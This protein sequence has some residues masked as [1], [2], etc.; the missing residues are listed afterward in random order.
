MSGAFAAVLGVDRGD[1]TR[2]PPP[3]WSLC[4]CEDGD[5]PQ[6]TDHPPHMA[7]L[8][9]PFQA[10]PSRPVPSVQGHGR[11]GD[12]VGSGRRLVGDGG[13]VQVV[14]GV[15]Q[16][17]E[18]PAGGVPVRQHHDHVPDP[19]DGPA[20]ADGRLLGLVTEHPPPGTG[21]A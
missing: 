16:E 3:K 20:A 11:R 19:L 13:A 15:E 1:A 4:H 12:G 2:T 7:V 18:R 10:P 17:L 21:L 14:A 8:D 6:R 9:V 5:G